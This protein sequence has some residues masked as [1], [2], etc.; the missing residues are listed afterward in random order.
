MEDFERSGLVSAERNHEAVSP[1]KGKGFQSSPTD[2]L[3]KKMK[4]KLNICFNEA[5]LA[6]SKLLTN[7]I[8]SGC[9]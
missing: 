7:I 8:G 9:E 3:R 6:T 5:R 2:F 4:E 1:H